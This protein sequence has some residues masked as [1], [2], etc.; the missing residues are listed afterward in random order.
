METCR[1]C[2]FASIVTQEC[3][4]NPPIAITNVGPRGVQTMGV[5]PPIVTNPGCGAHEPLSAEEQ[6]RRDADHPVTTRTIPDE[7]PGPRLVV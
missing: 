1:T 4:K 5:F 6:A 2:R 3:R 7:K